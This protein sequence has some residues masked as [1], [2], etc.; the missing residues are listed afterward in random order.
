MVCGRWRRRSRQRTHCTQTH[1]LTAVFKK[2]SVQSGQGRRHV[3]DRL[4]HRAGEDPGPASIRVS[5]LLSHSYAIWV[6][7]L[8]LRK[9]QRRARAQQREGERGPS[10]EAGKGHERKEV[11]KGCE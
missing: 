8:G 6:R 3:H 5:S 4:F 10:A 1:Y 2:C 11:R 7:R 9:I